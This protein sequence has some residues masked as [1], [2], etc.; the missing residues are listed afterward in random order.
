MQILDNAIILCL[1]FLAFF[2]GKKTSDHYYSD[3]IDELRYQIRLN[4]AKNGVGYV[5]QPSH[6]RAPIGQ[7][8]MDRLKTNGRAIQQLRNS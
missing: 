1:I 3:I 7:P 4:A 2:A 6:K 5:A 8:F